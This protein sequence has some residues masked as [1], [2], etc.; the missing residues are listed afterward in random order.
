MLANRSG[1]QV[2]SPGH[3][4]PKTQPSALTSITIG[5]SSDG[6]D[7]SE[8]LDPALRNIRS[9]LSRKDSDF[10]IVSDSRR[11]GG[12]RERGMVTVVIRMVFDPTQEVSPMVK[13]IF[14]KEERFEIGIVSFPVLRLLE[15]T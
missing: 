1:L 5:S 11:N 15:I 12:L 8:Q 6:E 14:E 3:S 13:K 9:G 7:A 2:K 10:E 4:P